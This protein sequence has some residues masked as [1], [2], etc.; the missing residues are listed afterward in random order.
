MALKISAEYTQ[1]AMVSSAKK[2][3]KF[4]VKWT[5]DFKPKK[6]LHEY[7]YSSNFLSALYIQVGC[8]GTSNRSTIYLVPL[9][10]GARWQCRL[11]CEH[12]CCYYSRIQ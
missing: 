10:E 6:L 8:E 3:I 1:D 5:F 11:G 12:D 9:P 7:L 2:Q 4:I